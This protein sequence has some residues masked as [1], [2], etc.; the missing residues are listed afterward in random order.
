MIGPEYGAVRI[1][2]SLSARVFTG[3]Y[4]RKS[5]NLFVLELGPSRRN[6][7]EA[8]G[9]MT[10][11]ASYILGY[12]TEVPVFEYA[13]LGASATGSFWALLGA[14]TSTPPTPPTS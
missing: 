11:T 13:R 14:M 3:S 9:E 12:F 1:G 2:M 8:N 4:S 10:F 7:T 6:A 5:G